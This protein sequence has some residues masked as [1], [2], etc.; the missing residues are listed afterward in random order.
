MDYIT[1]LI[2][3]NKALLNKVK[4]LQSDI[5]NNKEFEVDE[6]TYYVKY[7]KINAENLTLKEKIAKLELEVASTNHELEK[8]NKTIQALNANNL[9]G[10]TL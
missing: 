6:N 7:N 10:M 5:K 8:R 1:Y 2:K 3:A 9:K 4:Q